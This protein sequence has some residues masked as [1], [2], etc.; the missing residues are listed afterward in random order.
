MKAEAAVELKFYLFLRSA[1]NVGLWSMSGPSQ[2]TPK[3]EPHN[4]AL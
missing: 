3:K 2:F 4:P 1:L